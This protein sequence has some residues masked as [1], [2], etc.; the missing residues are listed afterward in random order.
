MS[1][2]ASAHDGGAS[3]MKPPQQTSAKG[4]G[5][6]LMGAPLEDGTYR[7][8]LPKD[9][10]ASY[11]KANASSDGRYR[12]THARSGVTPVQP[13]QD[14]RSHL[15]ESGWERFKVAMRHGWERVTRH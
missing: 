1:R 2:A 11:A 7:D 12:R 4:P 15:H 13:M 5:D 3:A 9:Y 8:G 14:E 10:D 6:P